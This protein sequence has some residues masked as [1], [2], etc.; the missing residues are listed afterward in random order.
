MFTMKTEFF[1][2]SEAWGPFI[3][4]TKQYSFSKVQS[5]DVFGPLPATMGTSRT[6]QDDDQDLARL[7]RK[8]ETHRG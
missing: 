5:I 8:R 7:R 1:I 2:R 6:D 4:V 3:R